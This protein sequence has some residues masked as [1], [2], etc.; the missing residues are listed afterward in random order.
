MSD[1]GKFVGG[2]FIGCMVGGLLGVLLAP[3]SGVETRKIIVDET[4]ATYK[5]AENAIQE[6]QKKAEKSIDDLQK[7]GQDVLKKVADSLDPDK[8]KTESETEEKAE[9]KTKDKEEKEKV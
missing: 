9:A 2:L 8:N 7:T 3:R 5:K 4:N 6:V 1:F